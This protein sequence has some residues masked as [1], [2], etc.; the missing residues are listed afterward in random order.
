MQ[1]AIVIDLDDLAEQDPELAEAV[2]ENT[3]RYNILL[4]DV[5]ESLLPDYKEKEVAA[6]VRTSILAEA[7]TQFA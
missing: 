2:K 6:Q 7:S 1:T 4:A 5:I 3:R